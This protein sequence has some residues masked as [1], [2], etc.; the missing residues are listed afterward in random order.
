M[1][2]EFVTK[3]RAAGLTLEYEGGG[4]HANFGREDGVRLSLCQEV[5]EP[6]NQIAVINNDATG[7]DYD[8]FILADEFDSVDQAIKYFIN[9]PEL[10]YA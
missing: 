3:S 10:A 2:H 9:L 1:E 7:C 5:L 4:I 6:G 8:D